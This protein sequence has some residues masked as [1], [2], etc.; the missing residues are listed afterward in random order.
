[1]ALLTGGLPGRNPGH[2]RRNRGGGAEGTAAPPTLRAGVNAPATLTK[3]CT[4]KYF[5]IS[6]FAKEFSKLS[7]RNPR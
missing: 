2:R 6:C 1:M 4:L 3:K 7:C 5:F